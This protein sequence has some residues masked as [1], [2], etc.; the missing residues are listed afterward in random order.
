MC[1]GVRPGTKLPSW[2]RT[3]A[4]TSTSSV[5]DLNVGCAPFGACNSTAPHSASVIRRISGLLLGGGNC[6]P[7]LIAF[8]RA[9]VIFPALLDADLDLVPAIGRDILR[10]VLQHV[11]GAKLVQQRLEHPAHRRVGGERQHL[12]GRGR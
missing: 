12:P 4:S 7:A 10:H 9:D 6:T 1:S 11:R 3:T 8:P 2:S 5:A